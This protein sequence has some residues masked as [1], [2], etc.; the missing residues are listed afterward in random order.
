[1]SNMS[2]NNNNN[3]NNTYFKVYSQIEKSIVSS[4]TNSNGYTKSFAILFCI[5]IEVIV[6]IDDSVE[7][8]THK[9]S[10]E[11]LFAN[12]FH[13]L[14]EGLTTGSISVTPDFKELCKIVSAIQEDIKTPS[15]HNKKMIDMLV[16]SACLD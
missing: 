3:T 12:Y 11:T 7:V 8:A 14:A 2:K 1:M 6:N 10:C 9:T 15:A 13:H 5:L 4:N 16:S